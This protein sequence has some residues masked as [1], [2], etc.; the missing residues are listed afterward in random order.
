MAQNGAEIALE[1]R[2]GCLCRSV[3]QPAALS[4]GPQMSIWPPASVPLFRY[5]SDSRSFLTN[6]HYLHSFGLRSRLHRQFGPIE[7]ALSVLPHSCLRWPDVHSSCGVYLLE[8]YLTYISLCGITSSLFLVTGLSPGP[9]T[10]YKLCYWDHLF[11]RPQIL[12]TEYHRLLDHDTVA[13]LESKW[14]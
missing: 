2:F 11:L 7:R 10:E 5:N 4:I 14:N 12:E 8:F 13:L 9:E 1:G 6:H 3:S